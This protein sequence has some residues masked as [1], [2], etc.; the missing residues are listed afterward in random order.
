MFSICCRRVPSIKDLFFVVVGKRS[1]GVRFPCT[2]LGFLCTIKIKRERLQVL[3]SAIRTG[4]QTDS[5]FH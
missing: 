4:D 2:L 3:F 1:K 5:G